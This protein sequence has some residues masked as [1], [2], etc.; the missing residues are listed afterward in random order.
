MVDRTAASPVQA[1]ALAWPLISRSAESLHLRLRS[2]Q[3]ADT[4]AVTTTRRPGVDTRCSL[5]AAG[6]LMAGGEQREPS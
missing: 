1:R 2:G 4:D 3:E 6:W 5:A